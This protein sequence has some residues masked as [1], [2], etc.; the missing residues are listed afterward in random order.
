MVRARGTSGSEQINLIVGGT[1]VANWTLSTSAQDYTYIGGAFGNVDVEFTNDGD[2][3]DV[4]LDYI[5]VNGEIR[6][7][8]DMDYNTA[9][10]GNGE[11]GGGSYS[12][13]MHC[14]GVIGFGHSDDCFS[15]SCQ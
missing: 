3:R 2:G 10:Y 9:T 11:C 8:E 6:Q 1:A 12:E 7:A 15:G 5:Q 14:S 4:I 13:V